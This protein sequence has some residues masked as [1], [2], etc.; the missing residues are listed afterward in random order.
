LVFKELFTF[1]VE[2]VSIYMS[3]YECLS[4]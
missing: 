1:P 4:L 3:E 2:S